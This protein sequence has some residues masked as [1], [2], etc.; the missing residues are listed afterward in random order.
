MTTI[1]MFTKKHY[2]KKKQT[3][4][5]NEKRF[6][7]KKLRFGDYNYTSDEEEHAKLKL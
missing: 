3:K 2:N 7:Y 5:S 6:D 1:M 4:C